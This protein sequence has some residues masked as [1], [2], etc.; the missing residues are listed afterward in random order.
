MTVFTDY[1]PDEQRLLTQAIG[2]A[3]ILVTVASP[4]SKAD[5]VSEGFAAAEYVLDSLGT[6]VANPLVS[7]VIVALKD[8]V[9]AHEPFPDYVRTATTAGAD[10]HA[11][12]VLASV[13]DLL[14]ARTTAEE[15]A[16]YKAWLVSVAEAAASAAL[17]DKGFLGFGGVEVNDAERAAIA[18]VGRLLGVTG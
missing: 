10:D 12:S 9:A 11:R 15:A 1:S 4:G 17:E 18:E 6:H 5:T 2:A 16:G 3:A 14:D 7:S 13:A 8:R